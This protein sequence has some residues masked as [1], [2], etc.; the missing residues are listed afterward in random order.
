MMLATAFTLLLAAGRVLAF[1]IKLGKEMMPPPGMSLITVARVHRWLMAKVQSKK[2]LIQAGGALGIEF[3]S[4]FVF[5][6]AVQ[7]G[8]KQLWQQR[9]NAPTAKSKLAKAKPNAPSADSTSKP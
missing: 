9:K 6:K 8:E 4:K 3:L 5:A 7:L 2:P 1:V